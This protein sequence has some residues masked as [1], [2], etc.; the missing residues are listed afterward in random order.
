MT[1]Q[2]TFDPSAIL[3]LYFRISRA[4]SKK[5]IFLDEDAEAYSIAASTFV[6]NVKTSPGAS[7]NVFQLTEVSGLTKGGV[8]NNELTIA[9]T[10]IQSALSDNLYYWEL[11][12][13]TTKKTW[14]SGNAYFYHQINDQLTSDT[15]V[16]IEL[17]STVTVTISD[18]A[19]SGSLELTEWTFASNAGAIPT[20]STAGKVY[21]TTDA[22]GSPGDSD[23]IPANSLMISKVAGANS[24][25]QYII[26]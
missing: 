6:L 7:T 16:T 15:E 23:Y 24:I 3:N 11:Y 9:V 5:L 1:P 20:A 8:G 17:D 25:S 12:N 19:N 21:T 10:E 18:T 14:L 4:G 2:A 13:T 26:K 22:K